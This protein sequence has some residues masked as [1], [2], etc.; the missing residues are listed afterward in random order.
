MKGPQ[1]CMC[2]VE[3]KKEKD[4]GFTQYF[5]FIFSFANIVALHLAMLWFSWSILIK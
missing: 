2:F 3:K 4:L 5:K 1:I